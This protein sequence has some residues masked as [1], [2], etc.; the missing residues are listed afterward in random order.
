MHFLPRNV[1][2]VLLGAMFV[3]LIA[4][5]VRL[6]A[7]WRT[8][9]AADRQRLGSVVVWWVIVA[10]LLIAAAVGTIAESYNA[11]LALRDSTKAPAAAHAER[12]DGL[13]PDVTIPVGIGG[14]LVM[15][16]VSLL[17]IREYFRLTGAAHGISG[18]AW[19][20]YV[21]LVVQYTCVAWAAP[22]WLF[23]ATPLGL[24]VLAAAWAIARGRTT[25]F[26]TSVS[27]FCWGTMLIVFF[28]SHAAI[29]W[30]IPRSA[31]PET[32][33]AGWFVFLI[34]LT[35][36]NDIAQALWGRA[37]GRHKITPHLS[38][39]KTWEG[40]LLGAVTT[41]VLSALL[42]NLLT[43]WSEA[44]VLTVGAARI[45]IPPFLPAVGAGLI[46]ALGGFIGDLNMS[47]LKRDLGVKDAGD[48]LP[49]QG[50]VLDRV[51]SLTFTA[52]MFFY[53][54]YAMYGMDAP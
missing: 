1:A 6:A 38:P 12:H 27:S 40:F 18:I 10:L 14:V 26:L 21:M 52:P 37:L 44:V 53:Y 49:S 2:Y 39:G 3:L 7:A 15:A 42:A 51:D 5:A 24:P 22:P 11:E 29:L 28:L 45:E 34:L 17:G 19:L 50:G 20:G 31:N 48:L 46:V 4:G 23:T 25:G 8:H 47:A 33:G 35:Q 16:G 32:G 41:L 30:R 43:P 54:V 36:S 13:S 9:A